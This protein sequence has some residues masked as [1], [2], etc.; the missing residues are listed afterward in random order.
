MFG[1]AQVDKTIM[2]E[3]NWGTLGN[4]A[5]FQACSAEYLLIS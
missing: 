1:L 5:L 3:I 4:K 2:P